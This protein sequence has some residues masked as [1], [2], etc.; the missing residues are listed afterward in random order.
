MRMHLHRIIGSDPILRFAEA[1]TIP[2][3]RQRQ[4]LEVA[5]VEEAARRFAEA[6]GEPRRRTEDV[7][8][9]DALGRVLAEDVRAPGDVPSFDRSNLDGFA[10]RAADTFGAEN[11][12]PKRLR[13]NAESLVP[14]DAPRVEV[15][16]GTATPIATG[17]VIPRGADAV[18]PVEHT[19]VE[20]DA[21][22]VR[23]PVVPGAAVSGAGSDVARG[24]TVLRAGTLL[25][26]RETGTLAAC[27]IPVVPCVAPPR[28]AVLSTGG[29]VIPPDAPARPGAVHDANGRILS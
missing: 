29:E 14:G 27:G 21:V 8:I 20:G 10:V 17:A 2:G 19:D 22:L 13:V 11:E 9:E 1:G 7:R 24:E 28:V 4:F 12:R 6:V 3:M 16:A 25:S 15:A 26:S 18:V 5:S 23:R